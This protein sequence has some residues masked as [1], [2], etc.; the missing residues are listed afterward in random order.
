MRSQDSVL[1]PENRIERGHDG[2]CRRDDDAGQNAALAFAL[3]FGNGVSPGPDFEDA[4]KKPP[5]NTS[6]SAVPKP[7]LSGW[8]CAMT[9]ALCEKTEW[10][11]GR[12]KGREQTVITHKPI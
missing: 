7:S 12:G 3:A 2:G 9:P 5:M 11:A 8:S 1:D 4:P 6:T 10:A